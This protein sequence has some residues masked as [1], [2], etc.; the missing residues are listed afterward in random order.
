MWLCCGRN[1]ICYF[2]C[3]PDT[4]RIHGE[5]MWSERLANNVMEID[6]LLP[7]KYWTHKYEPPHT[8]KICQPIL[9]KYFYASKIVVS[10]LIP[11]C[12]DLAAEEGSLGTMF[13][14]FCKL[15]VRTLRCCRSELWGF[16]S[17]NYVQI[18]TFLAPSDTKMVRAVTMWQ[19][20]PDKE[21]WHWTVMAAPFITSSQSVYIF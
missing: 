4:R 18:N 16:L 5:R 11:V 1:R 7:G 13:C 2:Y 3:G 8:L 19:H 9:R 17:S 6:P 15:Q 12:P 10:L 14:V 21:Y 20:S